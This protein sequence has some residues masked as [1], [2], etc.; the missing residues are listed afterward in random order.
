MPPNTP[1]DELKELVGKRG[2]KG[3]NKK[4]DNYYYLDYNKTDSVVKLEIRH[5]Y[6][7]H[8][9]EC[10]MQ[11]VCRS[12]KESY[13]PETYLWDVFEILAKI[14]LDLWEKDNGENIINQ[15]EGKDP[16]V[17][18]SGYNIYCST[19]NLPRNRV[20]VQQL[21]KPS[22]SSI[23]VQVEELDVA[24]VN[25][26]DRTCVCARC[27]LA[28]AALAAANGILV[29]APWREK[30]KNEENGEKRMVNEDGAAQC[31]RYV[32][33][34][35]PVLRRV[36]CAATRQCARAMSIARARGT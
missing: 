25:D 21:D 32:F 12:V 26:V 1:L 9:R 7:S 30:G 18:S 22:F 4:D 3:D 19:G 11:Q 20:Y 29:N 33:I 34:F 35:S 2:N 10:H 28:Q 5:V 15:R 23:D 16:A 17:R 24:R 13:K 14:L 36:P 8:E 27:N 31:T 6:Y